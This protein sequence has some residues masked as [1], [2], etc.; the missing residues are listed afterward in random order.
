MASFAD[1]AAVAVAGL[2]LKLVDLLVTAMRVAD[3]ASAPKSMDGP[4]ATTVMSNPP[5]TSEP[6]APRGL[7]YSDHPAATFHPQ[8][9][10]PVHPRLHELLPYTCT[11]PVA[12]V[13]LESPIQPPW[14]VLPWPTPTLHQRCHQV[15]K[16]LPNRADVTTAGRL[17][18]L[19]V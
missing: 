11:K 19:F 12:Q 16:I 14:K 1:I 10:L 9:V 7:A 13:R 4:A 15:V 2:D 3:V 5:A 17:L 6:A 18:D 8:A